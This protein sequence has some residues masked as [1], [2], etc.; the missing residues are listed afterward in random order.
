MTFAG[1]FCVLHLLRSLAKQLGARLLTYDHAVLLADVM[2]EESATD[3]GS[4]VDADDDDVD[5]MLG[6]DEDADKSDTSQ[7]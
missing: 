3:A 6:D 4:G 1:C 7:V 5:D 2:P